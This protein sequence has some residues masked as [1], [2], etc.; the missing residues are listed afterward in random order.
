MV[1][2]KIIHG[3]KGYRSHVDVYV[4]S[5]SMYSAGDI[6]AGDYLPEKCGTNEQSHANS[7][8]TPREVQQGSYVSRPYGR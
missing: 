1:F 5:Y 3:F 8:E 4:Y 6:P 2:T 7:T